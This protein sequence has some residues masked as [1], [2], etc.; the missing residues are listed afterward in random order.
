MRAASV[1]VSA[2][3]AAGRVSGPARSSSSSTASD[4]APGLRLGVGRASAA[5]RRPPRRRARSGRRLVATTQRPGQPVRR[6]RDE[7]AARHV[8]LL[9][10][11]EDEQHGRSARCRTSAADN[12]SSGSARTPS[13]LATAAGDVRA[14]RRRRR[15]RRARRT[16]RR[17]RTARCTRAASCSASRV[18]PQPPAPISVMSSP[19]AQ[20]AARSRASSSCGR[21]S[22]SAGPA[23]CAAM[24]LSVCR[25]RERRPGAQ[26][27]HRRPGREVLEALHAEIAQVGATARARRAASPDRSTW[28]GC[29]AR[30]S[31]QQRAGPAPARRVPSATT[32]PTWTPTAV[33]AGR[34]R[35]SREPPAA[36][37]SGSSNVA[38]RRSS[39]TGSEPPPWRSHEQAQRADP[40]LVA[41]P[42][43]R[44]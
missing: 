44:C 11:V 15:A 33:A 5:P 4:S 7:L 40:A 35:R 18:L 2:L 10:V 34:R 21:R 29:A 28:P 25:R 42:R 32:P 16:M 38:M 23:G 37:S 31:C 3:A 30:A 26:L 1:S 27:E 41:S 19:P 12:A 24:R 9:A 17:R 36:P 14:S 39:P 6:L 13:W 20:R 8:D 22:A 43:P